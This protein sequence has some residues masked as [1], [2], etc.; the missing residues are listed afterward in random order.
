MFLSPSGPCHD[1]RFSDSFKFLANSEP[2]LASPH[3]GI[4]VFTRLLGTF[5]F[6]PLYSH[7]F[8][9]ST[10][11]STSTALHNPYHQLPPLDPPAHHAV[12]YSSAYS[13]VPRH[14]HISTALHNPLPIYSKHHAITTWQGT[15]AARSLPSTSPAATRTRANAHPT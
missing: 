9:S 1:L 11:P 10:F 5:A 4:V 13:G 15:T 3:N 6:F 2:W 12:A 14:Q 7:S 8:P